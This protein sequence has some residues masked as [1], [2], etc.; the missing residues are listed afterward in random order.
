MEKIIADRDN[1]FH[2]FDTLYEL[3]PK[4]TIHFC[5]KILTKP[6]DEE[7]ERSNELAA[8]MREKIKKNGE[9]SGL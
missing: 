7:I 4:T 1:V 9:N 8:A 6:T 5:G 2:N 3:N